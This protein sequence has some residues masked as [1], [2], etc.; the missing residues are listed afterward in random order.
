LS[1]DIGQI[2]DLT[3]LLTKEGWTR[4]AD[5][6]VLFCQ[7]R[8]LKSKIKIT[9]YP[10]YTMPPR[11]SVIIPAYNE[12][13]YLPRL[14]D[15]IDRA[16]EASSF[17]V[18]VADNSSTDRTAEIAAKRG[19]RVVTVT[20]RSIAASRNGGASVANGE[21]LCFIDADSALHPETFVKIGE[22]MS[23]PSIIAGSTGIHLERRSLPI[24]LVYWMLMPF[25]WIFGIDTGVVFCR[26]RDFEEVGGYNE[27]LLIAEDV[28]FLFDLKRLGRKRAQKLTRVAGAEALG[29]TRKFDQHGDWH[30]F[31]ILPKAI[32]AFVRSGFRL[33]TRQTDIPGL[34]DYWYKPDR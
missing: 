20:K 24:L 15:S 16:H 21:V 27:D 18:I 1:G 12:E 4:F 28:T 13:R 31:A 29:S 5:G 23:D 7:D 34:T 26:R 9:C 33:R 6:V 3:P 11:F 10:S 22:A 30:Y 17:E 32:A 14:L 8:D 19:A 25:T 2:K